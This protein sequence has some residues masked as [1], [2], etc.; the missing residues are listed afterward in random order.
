MP[1]KRQTK[2]INS[3]YTANVQVAADPSIP[4][5]PV[6]RIGAPEKVG[7]KYPELYLSATNNLAA[8]QELFSKVNGEEN[9]YL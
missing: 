8:K 4:S 3:E 5:L 9:W 7:F 6:K 1:P 2:E